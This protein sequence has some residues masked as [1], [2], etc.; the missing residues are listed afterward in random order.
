M[1]DWLGR[2]RKGGGTA[3]W[4][5]SARG[6]SLEA[7][8]LAAPERPADP[9][10]EVRRRAAAEQRARATQTSLEASMPELEQWIEDQLRVGLNVF[11][12]EA[13]ERCRTIA[14]RL[15]D[16]KAHALARRLDEPPARLLAFSGRARIDF[17][18]QELGRIL[19]ILR[20]WRAT[21]N[22][23]ELHLLVATSETRESLLERADTLRAAE[24]WDGAR[25]SLL[26]A[27]SDWGRLAFDG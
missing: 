2:R 24:L 27:Q 5:P 15:V 9:N 6:K 14:A 23:P 26:A 25:L 7:A 17:L 19:L 18:S 11:L 16:G 21:P 13:G 3:P 4:K 10:A 22:D 1:G 8:R 12:A 20:A